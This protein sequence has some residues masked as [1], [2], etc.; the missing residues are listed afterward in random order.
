MGTAALCAL[1]VL[2]L[3]NRTPSSVPTP[4]LPLSTSFSSSSSSSSTSSSFVRRYARLGSLAFTPAP[5]PGVVE[6][7]GCLVG[8]VPRVVLVVAAVGPGDAETIKAWLGRLRFAAEAVI[9]LIIVLFLTA[10]QFGL[11]R[12]KR[13]S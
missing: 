1:C 4:K 2:W 13:A 8:A 10:I 12:Q 7:N 3:A 11:L 6:A 5:P 9:L